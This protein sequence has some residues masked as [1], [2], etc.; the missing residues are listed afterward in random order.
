MTWDL[1]AGIRDIVGI[2]IDYE[3][4]GANGPM[5]MVATS[6]TAVVI[7]T[8]MKKTTMKK[9][10]LSII[11]AVAALI[12]TAQ[13]TYMLN[14]DTSILSEEHLSGNSTDRQHIPVRL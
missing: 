1:F 10:F 11:L 3:T 7:W 8:E 6:G 9:S 5:L 12:A 13:N 14:F 2:D 4:V